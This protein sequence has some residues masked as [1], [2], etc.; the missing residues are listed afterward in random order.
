MPGSRRRSA[1][2]AVSGELDRV[3]NRLLALWGVGD[4]PRTAI[5]SRDAANPT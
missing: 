5:D 4:P 3:E 2:L 1:H